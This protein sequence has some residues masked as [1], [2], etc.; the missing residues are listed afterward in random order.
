MKEWFTARELAGLPGLPATERGVQR[1]A[2]ASGWTEALADARP[3]QGLGG[4]M[5]YH[6]RLLPPLARLA[7]EGQHRDIQPPATAT[8]AAIATPTSVVPLT[9]RAGRE[10]V[11]RL[12]IL[13]AADAFRRG[14]RLAAFT[15]DHLFTVKYNAREIK[16]E[17]WILD[18][19][20]R[21]SERSLARWRAAARDGHVSALAVDRAHRKGKG[22]LDTAH[23]G[24]VKRFVLSLLIKNPLLS[25]QHIHTLCRS[26]FGDTLPKLKDG[27]SVHLP[28][29]SIRSFQLQIATWKTTEKVMLAQISHPD[30]YRSHYQAAGSNAFAHIR[31]VNELWQIDASPSDAMCSDGRY[32]VYACLDIASRRLILLL[33]RTPRAAAVALMIRKAILAWGVP[34]EIVTDNG[35]DFVAGDT[36]RLLAVLGINRRQTHAY[37]PQAKGHVE[38]VIRTFQHDAARLMPGF[39]GHNVADRKRI[40]GRKSFAERL[41]ADDEALFEVAWTGPEMQ[42]R[43]DDWAA[44][45]YAHRPHD[46]LGGRSPVQVAA[47]AEAQIR[48][49]EPSVLDVLLMPVAGIRTA[50]KQG[51][52][53]D[54]FLYL[55]PAI[56]AGDRVFVRCDP[57]DRGRILCFSEDQERFLG[58]AICPEAAGLSPQAFVAAHQSAQAELLTAKRRELAAERRTI[59]KGPELI[60]RVIEVARR[61]A[62]RSNVVALPRREMKH[63]TPA[64]AAAAAAAGTAGL[65]ESDAG[66]TIDLSA[67]PALPLPPP[68]GTRPVFPDD[69]SYA[70]WLVAHPDD[71]RDHDRAHLRDRLRSWAFRQLLAGRGVEPTAVQ[72]LLDKPPQTLEASS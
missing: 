65:A 31:G 28:M 5:E 47:E 36:Q 41:G 51:V 50:S 32:S 23:D 67:A 58:E 62:E 27:V 1:H 60:D 34:A 18:L 53:V 45:V 72:A 15:C 59:A 37:T 66:L 21:V 4:G 56:L 48:R 44:M 40:E 12:A 61:D 16:T 33:S 14:Q 70:A 11:A 13:A 63:E 54:G 9:S 39:I 49:V 71:V 17:P 46:G 42:R 10:Q 20:P 19:V 38:R 30:L 6:I 3:R 8:P 25:A 69:V 7:V 43:C 29:P 22:L 57:M 24:R 35:S 2:K 52:R 68:A 26:E 64:I 55:N